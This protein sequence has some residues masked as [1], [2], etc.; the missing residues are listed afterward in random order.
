MKTLGIT[1]NGV[2]RDFNFQFEKFYRKK[3]IKNESLVGMDDNFF[4]VEEEETNEEYERI[5]NLERDL[6]N[7]PIDTADLLNHFKFEDVESFNS[8]LFEDYTF[9]IFGAAPAMPKSFDTLLKIQ[10]ISEASKY[11]EVV[12]ISTEKSQAISSTLHFLAK[13]GARIKN[14]KFVDNYSD[15]WKYCDIVLSETPEVFE[16]KTEGKTS[17]KLETLY[18]MYSQADYSIKNLSDFVE[19]EFLKGIFN[20]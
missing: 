19:I 15:V 12:L 9:P 13:N 6:I 10:Q 16:T 4:A 14:I 18:N 17:V 20:K 8:F 1:I 7:L 2:L 11:F 5:K 3:F